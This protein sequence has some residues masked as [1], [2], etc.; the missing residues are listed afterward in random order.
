MWALPSFR[1]SRVDGIGHRHPRVTRSRFIMRHLAVLL[2]L[3]AATPVVAQQTQGNSTRVHV[4]STAADAATSAGGNPAGDDTVGV[5]ALEVVDNPPRPTNTA[6]FQ[7]AL[8]QRYPPALRNAGRSGEVQVRFI[9]EVDGRVSNV[10]IVRSTDAAFNQP[11]LDVVSLLRFRPARLNGQPVRVWVRQPI[12]WMV[13][14][15]P[16]PMDRPPRP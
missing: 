13:Q 10:H 2:A 1:V 14:R 3:I 11:T 9:V 8:A 4:D 16:H 6:A 12:S 15:P 7:R 5:H